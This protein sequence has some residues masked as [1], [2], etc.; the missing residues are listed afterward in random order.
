MPL[1]LSDHEFQLDKG[2]MSHIPLISDGG[3][4]SEFDKAGGPLEIFVM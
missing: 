3:T 1:I 2:R 4:I